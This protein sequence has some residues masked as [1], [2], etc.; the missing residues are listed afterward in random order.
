MPGLLEC[1]VCRV[2]YGCVYTLSFLLIDEVM[3]D[4]C[5][6]CGESDGW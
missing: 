2:V 6:A 5:D 1:M 4:E 3:G